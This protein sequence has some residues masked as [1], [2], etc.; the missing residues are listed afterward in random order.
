MRGPLE[1]VTAS[2]MQNMVEIREKN[3]YFVTKL[4]LGIFWKKL[5]WGSRR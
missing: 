5:F 1:M 3:N 2:R 4:F